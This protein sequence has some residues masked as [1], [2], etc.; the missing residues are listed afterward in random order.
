MR[1]FLVPNVIIVAPFVLAIALQ[2]SVIML[3][4]FVRMSVVAG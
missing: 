1:L 2:H 3:L 4:I